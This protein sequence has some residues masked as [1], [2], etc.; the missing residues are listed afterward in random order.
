MPVIVILD[1]D[2]NYTELLHAYQQLMKE[3]IIPPSILVG[4][5]YGTSIMKRGNYRNRD[6]LPNKIKNLES[7]NAEN[8]AVFLNEQ[9]IDHLSQ[10]PID[11]NN[12]TL[13]AHSYGGLFL[14][15]LLTRSSLAYQNLIISS[16][17][18]WQDKSVLKK[19]KSLNENISQKIFL[20]SGQL[21]DNDKSTKKLDKVLSN[22]TTNLR[23][24]LYPNDSH[25][26]VISS[27]FKDALIYLNK[28]ESR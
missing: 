7:G 24:V 27:A 6:F 11:K 23:T 22:R 14:T 3:G 28:E 20:A 18:I 12:T 4:I 26:S 17:A 19:L 25:I 15:Y 10:Y 8:F 13:Q 1:S 16:P 21:N 9:L 2:F 5:G